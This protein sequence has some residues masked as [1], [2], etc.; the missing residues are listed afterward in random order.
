MGNFKIINRMLSF[1]GSYKWIYIFSLIGGG[2]CCGLRGSIFS[3]IYKNVFDVNKNKIVISKIILLTVILLIS[4][5]FQRFF[6]FLFKRCNRY[7]AANVRISVFNKLSKISIDEFE[8]NHS[9]NILSCLNN[10]VPALEEVYSVKMSNLMNTTIIGIISLCLIVTLD[11]RLALIS[12]I[13]NLICCLINMKFIPKLRKNNKSILNTLSQLLQIVS[14]ALHANKEIKMFSISKQIYSKFNKFNIMNGNIIVSNSKIAGVTSGIQLF[15]K[16]VN[17][18][19]VLLMGLFLLFKDEITVGVVVAII[20]QQDGIAFMFNNFNNYLND[21][22]KSLIGAERV[23]KFLDF[24]EEK[25]KDL[26]ESSKFINKNVIEFRNVNFSYK[27]TKVL[28]NI[29]LKLEKNNVI[30]IVGESGSGKSTLLKILMSFYDADSG[31]I[32]IDGKEIKTYNLKELRN[33]IAYVPQDSYLFYGTVKENI[34]YGLGEIETT[35]E[36]IIDAAKKASAHDFIMKLPNG[37][38]TIIQEKSTNLSGGE[39]QRIAIARAFLKNAP[40]LLL[41]E[42][43]SALDKQSEEIVKKSIMKLMENRTVLIV[44]HKI[45]TIEN[46]DYIYKIE[47]GNIFSFDQTLF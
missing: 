16:N 4:A 38:D 20:L 1:I 29:N 24:K 36:L 40:I 35:E 47:K 5:L 3:I 17:F 34:S 42:P 14:D 25:F 18:V 41:D 30:V 27:D 22:Q 23:F 39:K 37:Y 26:I 2:I 31:E 13:L 19:G 46:A 11:Y 21:L 10:D 12:I 8:A 43:T 45:S 9:A 15:L 44:T 32:F 7:V 6:N 33:K 28:N